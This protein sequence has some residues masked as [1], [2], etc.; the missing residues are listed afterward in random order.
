MRALTLM[1]STIALAL[2]TFATNAAEM[3]AKDMPKTK[4]MPA[5][6]IVWIDGDIV[7]GD[8]E[9]FSRIVS[10]RNRV[11]VALNSDGGLLHEGL[12]IGLLIRHK[13]MGTAVYKDCVSVCAMMWLAGTFRIVDTDARIGFHAAYRTEG[14]KPIE[15]GSGNALIGGYL[16][17]LGFSWDAIGYLTSA[18]PD[19]VEWLNGANAKKYGIK[20]STYELKK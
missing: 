2:T 18:P 17:R 13:A 20:V 10:N 7:K 3:T 12:N 16:M 6:S 9:R 1:A 11:M 8:H 5:Y 14:D 4:G 19:K 15:S